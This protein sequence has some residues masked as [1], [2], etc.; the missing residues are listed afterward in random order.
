MVTHP[1]EG[2]RFDGSVA[3]VTGGAGGIGR[4]CALAFARAGADV[5]VADLDEAA[6]RTVVSDIESLGRRA[7]PVRTDVARREEVEA[8]VDRSIDWQGHCDLFFSNA[9]VAVA[10]APHQVPLEDWEWI[11]DV[12]MWSHVWAV[13]RVLPHM[14]ERG[15]GYLLHTASASGLLGNPTTAPYVMTKFAVVGLAESL[16]IWCAGTGV[17]VSIVCPMVVATNIIRDGRATFPPGLT[18][19]EVARR[20]EKAREVMRQTGIPP[21]RAADDIVAG[22]R[23]GSLYILTHPELASY[24]TTKWRSPDGWLRSMVH[25][26]RRNPHAM[27]D[28]TAP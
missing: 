7:I 20:A 25:L 9:G 23:A 8:L 14:L 27:G 16:A 24:V 1:T 5:V 18:P 10:G 3:V 13:R 26:Y 11:V 4:A 19:E 6:S 12:N 21:E 15:S 2:F 17:G 28:P 22:V